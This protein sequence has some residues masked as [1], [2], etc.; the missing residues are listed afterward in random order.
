[1]SLNYYVQDERMR[2]HLQR[3]WPKDMLEF[4]KQ[5][6]NRYADVPFR[7]KHQQPID[8]LPVRWQTHMR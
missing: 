6:G 5:S 8:R 4:A 1:V 7:L 2:V 3:L